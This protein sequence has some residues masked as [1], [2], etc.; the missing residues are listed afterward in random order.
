[1][2]FDINGRLPDWHWKSD[3]VENVTPENLTKAADFV[4]EMVREL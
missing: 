2:A 1:M 3:T 4:T